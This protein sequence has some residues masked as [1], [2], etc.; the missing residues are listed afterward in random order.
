MART[1]INKTALIAAY[2]TLPVTANSADVVFVATSGSAGANGNQTSFGDAGEL[3]LMALNSDPTNPYTI[4]ISSVADKMN[5]SGDI[6]PYTMQA[7][8]HA[9]FTIKRDGFRQTDG[10]LY[11]ESNNAAVKVAV[12][13]SQA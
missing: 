4:L 7:G 13:E 10:N 12:W 1:N 8:E 6:G 9:V 3:T 2:P 11:F 5:R